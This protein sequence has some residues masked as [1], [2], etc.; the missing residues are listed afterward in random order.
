[1][2]S[3]NHNAVYNARIPPMRAS[4]SPPSHA[5]CLLVLILMQAPIVFAS[6]WRVPEEQLARQIAAATG[7]GAVS[8]DVVNRSS[9]PRA[10]VEEV[11]RGLVAELGAHGVRFVNADQA[12]ATVQITL[13]E[14]LQNYVW[15]AEIHQGT[16]EPSVV[17]AVTP[18]LSVAA[19]ERPASA[20]TIRK[21]LLWT[22]EHRILDVALVSG[23]PQ[24][25]IV[26]EPESVILAK[27]QDGRWQQ[28]QA[29]SL[30]H[31]RPWPRD[32]RGR[33]ALRK[34]HLFD[35]Y[36]PGIF[37]RST[38][39]APLSINC[40]ES[41]DPWP[42]GADQSGLS[43]FFAS[44]RNFFTGVLSPGIEKQTTV[45]AF[46][47]AAMLPRERYKLWMFATVDGQVH[48][49]DGVTDQTVTKLGWGD[50]VASVRSGCGLGWQVLVAG[51]GGGAV[52]TV[53]AFEIADREPVAVSPPAEFG[54]VITALWTDSDGTGAI[55]VSQNSETGRYEAYRLS[56]ACGQ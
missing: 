50:E 22:D 24:H 10:D 54:G 31:S 30:S 33:L 53:K 27:L 55:A 56:I 36:L 26:L 49:L 28:E 15:A 23:S 47:S 14:N 17:M 3:A 51:N 12:A 46:Y 52:E 18:R 34:D 40:Y 41:D 42:L 38:A 39:A 7:P 16:N 25:M 9:L 44:T 11:R 35:A 5:A 6:D 19:I 43:A 20:L 8:L 4:S 21:T 1:M 29:L 32:L 45:K 2:R 48:M 13:S 37:C